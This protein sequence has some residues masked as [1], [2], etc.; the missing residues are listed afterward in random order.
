MPQDIAVYRAHGHISHSTVAISFLF[1]YTLYI[2]HLLFPPLQDCNFYGDDLAYGELLGT[3]SYDKKLLGIYLIY[4]RCALILAVDA[5]NLIKDKF[6]SE[7]VC[8]GG[9]LNILQC[10]PDFPQLLLEG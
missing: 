2:S 5:F 3:C 9:L 4:P 1:F 10:C 7:W 8:R 6:F